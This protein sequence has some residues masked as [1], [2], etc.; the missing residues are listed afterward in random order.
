M[1]HDRHERSRGPRRFRDRPLVPRSGCVGGQARYERADCRESRLLQPGRDVR[2]AWHPAG[3]PAAACVS[4]LAA[5]ELPWERED[6][7]TPIKPFI[8]KHPVLTYY[9][10]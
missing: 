4:T 1:D 6:I 5:D 8:E 3:R 2:A 9:A 10:L 7:V